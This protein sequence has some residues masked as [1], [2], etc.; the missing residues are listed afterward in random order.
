MIICRNAN[1]FCFFFYLYV[2]AEERNEG[3]R[4]DISNELSKSFEGVDTRIFI[5]LFSGY[6]LDLFLQ[7]SYYVVFSYVPLFQSRMTE[8]LNLVIVNLYVLSTI[9]FTANLIVF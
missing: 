9:V 2:G 3:I 6:L 1:K 7:S 5:H 4:G 8:Y